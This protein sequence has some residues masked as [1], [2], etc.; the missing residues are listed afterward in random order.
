MD[1]AGAVIGPLHRDRRSSISIPEAY[2]TLFVL[3][4][5]PG[6]IV[7]LILLRVPD[8]RPEQ[9]RLPTPDSNAQPA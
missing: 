5:V 8:T 1:H 9:R 6:I 2:R 4:L 3:T 7:I